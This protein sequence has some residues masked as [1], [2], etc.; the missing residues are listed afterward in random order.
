[1]KE[2]IVK[3]LGIKN[4][5][6]EIKSLDFK[7]NFGNVSW[8]KNVHLL[9]VIPIKHIFGKNDTLT[10]SKRINQ[11]IVVLISIKIIDEKGIAL[12]SV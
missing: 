1:M 4:V 2:E 10:T 8:V 11:R 9:D 3:I 7:L 12:I 6:F 5:M